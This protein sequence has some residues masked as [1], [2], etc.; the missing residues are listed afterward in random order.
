MAWE[1]FGDEDL[2]QIQNMGLKLGLLKKQIPMKELIDRD[3]VPQNITAASIDAS[4]IPQ[5]KK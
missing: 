1:V 5:S 2:Q 3:F 4:K